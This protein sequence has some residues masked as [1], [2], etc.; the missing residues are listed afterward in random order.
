MYDERSFYTPKFFI[1]QESKNPVTGKL[2]YSYKPDA[3]KYWQERDKGTWDDM[4]KIFEDGCL[5][6]GV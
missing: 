6:F 2:E 5:P 4:P 3:N 1:K